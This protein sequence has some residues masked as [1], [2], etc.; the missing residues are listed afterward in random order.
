VV[1][2]YYDG[3]Q[4]PVFTE[5]TCFHEAGHAVA[6][7]VYGLEFLFVSLFGDNENK[8]GVV[9]EQ[10]IPELVDGLQ[11]ESDQVRR[12]LEALCVMSLAGEASESVNF[13]HE[14]DIHRLSNEGDLAAIGEWFTKHRYSDEDRAS[15]IKEMEVQAVDFVKHPLRNEQIGLVASRLRLHFSLSWKQVVDFMAESKHRFDAEAK[16]TG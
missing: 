12:R 3:G 8:A 4:F 10:S 14:F 16:L 11:F 7:V 6:A 9:F 13:G 1:R 15:L 5:E 2:E